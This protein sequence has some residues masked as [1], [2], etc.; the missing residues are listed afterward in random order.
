MQLGTALVCSSGCLTE[1]HPRCHRVAGSGGW[2][3]PCLMALC[4]CQS[5]KPQTESISLDELDVIAM[6]GA[7]WR[8]QEDVLVRVQ[9]TAMG[10]LQVCGACRLL[11]VGSCVG[12]G[13]GLQ[14]L[15]QPIFVHLRQGKSHPLQAEQNRE[16]CRLFTLGRIL[17]TRRNISREQEKSLA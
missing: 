8:E 12:A 2:L 7:W 6:A 3:L 1:G 16:S 14:V 9:T 5:V 13:P 4:S 15:L 10:S 17:K 11:S